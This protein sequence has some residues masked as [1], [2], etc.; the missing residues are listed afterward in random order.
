MNILI[1]ANFL[2]KAI[3]EKKTLKNHP[4]K[5]LKTWKRSAEVLLNRYD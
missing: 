1:K 5:Q 3:N 4:K 2:R